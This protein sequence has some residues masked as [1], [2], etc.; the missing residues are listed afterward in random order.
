MAREEA[1]TSDSGAL[2]PVSKHV[3]E[4]TNGTIED[5][6]IEMKKE[7]NE[8]TAGAVVAAWVG[9]A[10]IFGTALGYFSGA[11]KSEEF[12]AG[13]L[14]EQSLSIDNLFVFILIFK[15]FKVAMSRCPCQSHLM[16]IGFVSCDTDL[17]GLG[18]QVKGP[19]QETVLS[20]GIWTAAVLRGVMAF[21]GVE[22]VEQFR[23]VLLGFAVLL[24]YS[25]YGILAAGDSD[26]E[27]D[28]NDNA[29]VKVGI[30]CN[31]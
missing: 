25:A 27:E 6:E 16:S 3:S 7:A 1:D 21:A 26:E 20:Y 14:L 10:M 23:P 30:P 28:I 24:L 4:V 15:Y 9:A 31:S 22:L 5:L 29:V 2:Q 12:F 18:T 11:E 17:A 19:E 8:E 13:Y